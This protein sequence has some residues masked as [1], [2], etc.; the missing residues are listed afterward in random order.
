[1][2]RFRRRLPYLL[3]LT[4]FWVIVYFFVDPLQSGY[5]HAF[6]IQTQM[7]SS[8]TSSFSNWPLPV[9]SDGMTVEQ[10][11]FVQNDYI[12]GL[13]F[14]AGTYIRT[15]TA[16]VEFRITDAEGNIVC[17]YESDT[18]T[19]KDNDYLRISF[20]P[21][22]DS[23]NKTYMVTI[24]GLHGD[25]SNSPS[26]WVTGQEDSGLTVN[27]EPLEG[28]LMMRVCYQT[29]G[30]PRYVTCWLLIIV[31]SY[32]IAL[33]AE[34]ADEKSYLLISLTLGILFV[35]YNPFP[36]VF[37]EMTHFFKSYCVSELK[38]E[39]IQ[40]GYIGNDILPELL[41]EN[42]SLKSVANTFFMPTSANEDFYVNPYVASTIP[43]NHAIG[44]IGIAIARIL[45]FSAAGIIY[46]GRMMIY[47][48]YTAMCY[49]AIKNARY[50]KSVFFAVALLPVSQWISASFSTDP[51][52][53]SGSLLFI[54][55]CMKY[56]LVPPPELKNSSRVIPLKDLALLLLGM[57]MLSSVKYCGYAPILLLFFLIPKDAIYQRQR[58]NLLFIGAF[59][60]VVLA[61][62]QIAL[63]KLYPY[64]EDRNG[65]TDIAQQLA[66]ISENPLSTFDLFLTYAVENIVSRARD[67]FITSPIPFMSQAFSAC[68]VLCAICIPDKYT[69][70]NEKQRKRL[71]ILFF[72]IFVLI[73]FFNIAS[74][75]LAFTPVGKL[76]IDGVQTRYF[77]PQ[78]PLL[79]ILLSSNGIVNHGKRFGSLLA[80]LMECSILL[81]LIGCLILTIQG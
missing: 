6:D 55:L 72:G 4:F 14:L 10:P 38:V 12:A 48:F 19:W 37:D 73:S 20:D 70:E 81:S 61:I 25:E 40:D 21:Q 34:H 39:R 41:N 53:I 18:S 74:L 75:Y 51:M 60:L 57:I 49:L 23:A 78:L 29:N 44:A 9:L 68:T 17:D 58:R 66:F 76:G 54:S 33:F 31:F 22:P 69:F 79:M 16:T 32:V 15:N 11:F 5:V 35:F 3:I 71:R 24:T 80:L 64:K 45:G 67:L 50:Y 26:L 59:V 36:H 42:Y 63:L 46:F 28:Q 1:M 7:L 47:L 77:I 43:I 13:E 65:Y 56:A 52:L 8:S 30:I 62:W 2:Q 27:G